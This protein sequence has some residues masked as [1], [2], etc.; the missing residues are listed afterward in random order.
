MG[1]VTTRTKWTGVLVQAT[2][3]RSASCVRLEYVEA[4]LRLCAMM[5]I[6][7]GMIPATPS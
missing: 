7:V 6:G 5:G 1:S 4:D 3:V 2:P